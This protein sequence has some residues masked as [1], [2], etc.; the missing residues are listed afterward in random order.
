MENLLQIKI[1]NISKFGIWILIHDE[2]FFINFE[3]FPW[4]RNANINDIFNV[5]YLHVNHLY[6]PSLDIDITLNSLR[7]PEKYPLM[8]QVK[9]TRK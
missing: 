4:F 6:W 5:E 8:F 3:D 1:L 2:E 9:K 7:D